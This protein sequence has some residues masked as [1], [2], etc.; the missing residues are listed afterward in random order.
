MQEAI[1]LVMQ[2]L[3]AKKDQSAEGASAKPLPRANRGRGGTHAPQRGRGAS[4]GT[5]VRKAFAF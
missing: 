3:N 2:Q 5:P 1:R 4:K